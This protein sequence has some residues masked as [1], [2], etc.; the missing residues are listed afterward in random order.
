VNK[1]EHSAV[2]RFQEPLVLIAY[3]LR[4]VALATVSGAAAGAG[5]VLFLKFLSWGIELAHGFSLWWVALPVTGLVSSLL[6]KHVSPEAYGHGTEAVIRAVNEGEGRIPFLAAPIKA[7]TTVL[8]ISFGASAGKEGPSAQIG[9]VIASDIGGVLRVSASDRRTLAMSGLAAGFAVVTGAPVAGVLF[10]LEALRMGQPD[11]SALMPAMV[12]TLS[13]V[14]VARWMGYSHPLHASFALP[15]A[16]GSL[17]FKLGLL[18]L[19]FGMVAWLYIEAE[20]V[21]AHSFHRIHNLPVRTF[22]GGIVL[23]LLALV[24]SREYMGL[25]VEIY[26]GALMGEP[27]HGAAFLLKI[28]FVAVTL[29]SGFSGGAMTPVFVIGAAAGSAVGK[30]FMLEPAF[31]AALGIVGVLAGAANTPLAAVALGVESFGAGFGL[32]A[33][34]VA[35]I[36]YVVSGHR[37]INETQ[38]LG[39]PK[40]SWFVVD[41]CETCE[42]G[43]GAH[44][45]GT[46]PVNSYL[47]NVPRRGIH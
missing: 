6:I 26:E 4:W 20:H 33:I 40:A 14:T 23:V 2:S 30:Y 15:A 31:V 37:S 16:D 12:S 46:A 44:L 24:F 25:G 18:A 29:G 8:C 39:A 47:L 13:S 22:V 38:L 21:A 7:I 10:A 19:F 45:N 17:F 34:I 1:A 36:A 5:I 11:Y 42:D 9:A 3:T 28:L 41:P 35:G 32:Y 27:V 43:R